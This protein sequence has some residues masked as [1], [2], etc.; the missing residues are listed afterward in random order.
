MAIYRALIPTLSAMVVIVACSP[1]EKKIVGKWTGPDWVIEFKEDGT[2]LTERGVIGSRG[3]FYRNGD[4]RIRLEYEGVVGVL[5]KLKQTI[6]GPKPNVVK[7]ELK[8]DDL[9]L[10]WPDGEVVAYRR[11]GK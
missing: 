8:G 9:S 6:T 10:T 5:D 2:F 4:D 11:A 1:V 7:V 3:R